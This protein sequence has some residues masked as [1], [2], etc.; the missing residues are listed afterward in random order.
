MDPGSYA[1]IFIATI[2]AIVSWLTHRSSTKADRDSNKENNRVEMEKEAYDR[3]RKLDTETIT[4]QDNEI[5]ELIAKN[6]NLVTRNEELM[7]TNE[8]LARRNRELDQTI[9]ELQARVSS[10]EDHVQ[11]LEGEKNEY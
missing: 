9:R 2:G 4:R 8:L 10:L 3:A 11:T 7:E 5:N 6:T 1:A